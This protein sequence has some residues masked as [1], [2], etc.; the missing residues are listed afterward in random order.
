MAEEKPLFVLVIST[1]R[2]HLSD[3]FVTM[4]RASRSSTQH[5]KQNVTEHTFLFHMVL[6]EVATRGVRS[7][8]WV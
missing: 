3:T 6:G 2:A 7:L 5:I 1:I 8:S 4:A